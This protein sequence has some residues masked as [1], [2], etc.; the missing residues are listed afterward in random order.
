M[1]L[2]LQRRALLSALP[3][4]PLVVRSARGQGTYPDRPIRLLIGSSAGGGGDTVARLVAPSLSARLGQPIVAE[5]R[6]GAAGNIAAEALARAPADGYTLL[7][8]FTGHVINP[9]LFRRLPFDTARDFAAVAPLANNQTILL[10]RA[11]SPYRTLGDLIAAAK[12]APGRLNTG[13][14]QGTTQHLANEMFLRAAGIQAEGVPYRGNGPAMTDLLGGTLDYMFYTLSA[15]PQIEAGRL[16]ALGIT[17]L[18]RSSLLPEVPT[19]DEDGLPGFTATGFY[20]LVAPAG[21]PSA[22]LARLNEAT[23][24]A[25]R[26]EEVRRRL[27]EL[28][29]EPLFASPA[30]F[31]R[32]LEGEIPRWAAVIRDARI[33]PQ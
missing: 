5:N 10:V 33:E 29:A 23:A 18:R 26:E 28:G 12:A 32:F 31:G 20:G 27:V 4:L 17:E 22:I 11:D 7:L 21:T 24:A 8:I 30:E 6:P 2:R 15:L 16:R 25:L 19:F 1:P 13:Y 3:A 9:A 14:L